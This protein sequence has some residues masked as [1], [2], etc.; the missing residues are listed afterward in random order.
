MA[1]YVS[2]SSRKRNLVL[3]VVG[4]LLVGLVVGFVIGR[5]T[6]KGLEDEVGAVHDQAVEAATAFQR[7]PIEYEQ[8]VGGDG[9]EST[10]TIDD[11]IDSAD[12]QLHAVYGE[13]IWLADDASSDTDAAVA[14]LRKVVED[15]GSADEFQAATDEVVHAIE[16]T[17][18]VTAEPAG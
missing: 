11:A 2:D 17:F 4:A 18:G 1:L 10:T 16:A 5:A 6:S 8:A 13:A 14:D 9:G 12:D 7:I 3:G 15:G